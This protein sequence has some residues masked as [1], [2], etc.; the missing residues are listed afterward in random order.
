M[1]EETRRSI[2]YIQYAIARVNSL[3]NFFKEK[4]LKFTEFNEKIFDRYNENEISLMK[5]LSLWPKVIET[6]IYY[7]N[8][9]ELFIT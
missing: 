9:I 5:I 3:N 6:S 2:F 4:K 1:L 8:L 7:R